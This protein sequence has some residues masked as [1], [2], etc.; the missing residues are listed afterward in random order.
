MA[1]R[2]KLSR[3][4][5][6]PRPPR[7]LY[8][9]LIEQMYLR[10]ILRLL[11]P[12]K[13][14]VETRVLPELAAIMRKAGARTDSARADD[15]DYASH[16]A[17]VFDGI[18]LDYG[19]I[20][21][22]SEMRVPVTTAAIG[23]SRFNRTQVD[24]Q[25]KTVLGIDVM[26]SEPWLEPASRTFTR[27]NVALIK[28]IPQR[29]FGEIEQLVIG[30][31]RG[32][33]RVEDLQR[34]IA[35][36]YDVSESRAALIARDQVGKWNGE[37]TRRRHED[38]GLTRYR[39]RTSM[40]ERVRG[41]PDGLY[42]KAYPSHWDREGKIYS[43][44]EPPDG[45]NPGED[46]QCRCFPEPVFEDLLGEEGAVDL[47][48][49]PAAS[50]YVEATETRTQI[51]SG[52]E[53]VITD[54]M[55]LSAAE[56]A[57]RGKR[58]E[59]IGVFSGS[60]ELL[61]TDVGGRDSVPVPNRLLNTMRD[62][63]DTIVTH[64]HP[65]G[66]PLSPQD[67]SIAITGNAKE[68]RATIP[69]GGAWVMRRPDKGWRTRIDQAELVQHLT[70]AYNAGVDEALRKLT[71]AVANGA[72]REKAANLFRR[73]HDEEVVRKYSEWAASRGYRWRINRER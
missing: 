48:P 67:I 42:P 68:I 69:D 44:D 56:D 49:V 45:G 58:F 40:D 70:R 38:L 25:I 71:E 37:L 2:Q 18:T 55:T 65:Q 47:T 19:R 21:P 16:I 63:R 43:Y 14:L 20:V 59:H 33:R 12:A 62:R 7:L 32:G 66:M 34:D 73:L 41:R 64:N 72:S 23:T 28:S 52:R 9:K 57:I 3:R 8:P 39:W 5:R 61:H 54:G 4:L 11:T 35:D 50:T 13:H 53:S 46:Y 6:L 29:Y 27:Q 1:V 51:S 24:R 30:A 10:D 31:A 36:R 26:Q 60:G 15:D 22:E 17:R